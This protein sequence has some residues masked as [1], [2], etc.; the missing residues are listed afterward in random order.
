MSILETPLTH[1]RRPARFVAFALT[2]VLVLGG[3]T[4]RLFAMQLAGSPPPAPVPVLIQR[5]RLGDETERV[6]W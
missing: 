5:R 4:T 6:D 2:A 1:E 3:L